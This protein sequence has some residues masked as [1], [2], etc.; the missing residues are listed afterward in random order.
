MELY[1]ISENIYKLSI[2]TYVG[3]P[4]IINTWYIIEDSKVYIIDTGMDEY[5]DLQ[6]KIAKQLGEPQAILLTHGHLDHINGA[7]SLKSKLNIPIY[8]HPSELPYINGEVPY[9]NN[10]KTENTG[11]EYQVNPLQKKHFHQL[12]FKFYHTPG[13]A[14]G[15]VVFY[16]EKDSVLICGDLFISQKYTLHPP[17]KKFTYNM[18]ANINSGNIINK[19]QPRIITTA[20]GHDTQFR[21]EMYHVYKFTYEEG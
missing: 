4:V 10:N 2:K 1:N 18:E 6:S 14:P 7:K 12:P 19:L 8:A 3:M 11:V 15:H 20:H 16:H 5:T 13:H 17:I 9:P 21:E